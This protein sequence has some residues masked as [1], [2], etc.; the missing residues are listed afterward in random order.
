MLPHPYSHSVTHSSTQES[1]LAAAA[2]QFEEAEE[3][4]RQ[5]ESEMR[6]IMEQKAAL[7][8]PSWAQWRGYVFVCYYRVLCS[9]Y[10]VVHK[11]LLYTCILDQVFRFRTYSNILCS[12]ISLHAPRAWC[13]GVQAEQRRRE[14]EWEKQKVQMR[15]E[16]ERRQ[17]ELKMQGTR[18]HTHSDN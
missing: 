18:A 15:Q 14:E 1:N 11:F 3:K 9:L 7:A 10:T 6:K 2:R 5:V 16:E 8:V 4:R 12:I 17:Q 13:P